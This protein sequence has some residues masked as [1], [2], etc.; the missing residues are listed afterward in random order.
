MNQK[1]RD[2]AEALAEYL[3]RQAL[4]AQPVIMDDEDA[5]RRDSMLDCRKLLERI[6]SGL[7]IARA[8]EGN[9][10]MALDCLFIILGYGNIPRMFSATEVGQRYGVKKA[11]ASKLLR[12]F[13]RALELP[14]VRGQRGIEGTNK[15]AK[16]RRSQL[17]K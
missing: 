5:E 15:M 4:D 8:Y 16:Q 3:R 14:P 7:Q 13:Q 17:T 12:I 10:D 11:A 1:E 9:R 6:V 2:E